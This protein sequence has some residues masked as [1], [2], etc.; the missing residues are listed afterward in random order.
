MF[1]RDAAHNPLTFDEKK[2]LIAQIHKLPPNKMEH[3]LDIIQAALPKNEDNDSG[4]IEIP[5]DAL[6]TFTLRKLQ[7]FIEDSAPKKK[8]PVAGVP[9]LQRQ[10]SATS[11]KSAGG[12]PNAVKKPRKS[13]SKANVSGMLL[14]DADLDLL[15][16]DDLLFSTDS[17]EEL[18]GQ[19]SDVLHTPAPPAAGSS[20]LPPPAP[21]AAPSYNTSYEAELNTSSN[22]SGHDGKLVYSCSDFKYL[23]W[24][25]SL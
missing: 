18:R 23:I 14:G 11:T 3:V 13:A 16:E 17:F 19:G 22:Q 12:D 1:D 21:V 9:P 7:K 24:C 2:K 25:V 5:L 15:H 10:N 6:D 8:P 20:L 4:D